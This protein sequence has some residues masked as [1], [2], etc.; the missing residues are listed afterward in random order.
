M[1]IVDIEPLMEELAEEIDAAQ[2]RGDTERVQI[3][4]DELNDINSIHVIDDLNT[5]LKI[6]RWVRTKKKL[7]LIAVKNVILKLKGY[8]CIN[9]VLNAE[10]KCRIQETDK[11]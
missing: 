11:S 10:Q 1:R 8:F 7:S 4:T 9:I 5:K 3:F 2:I 6:S